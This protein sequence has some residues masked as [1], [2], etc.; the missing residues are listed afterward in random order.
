MSN[1]RKDEAENKDA[2][3][4][5]R[6]REF[7][8]VRDYRDWSVDLLES[9]EEGKSVGIVRGALGPAQWNQIKAMSLK[10]RDLEEL[11]D[12]IAKAL[13]FGSVGESAPS[14]D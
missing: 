9:I 4:T 3:V 5:F 2:T 13:G 11:A 7:T 6:G 10:V 8:V 12:L 1:P 14:S